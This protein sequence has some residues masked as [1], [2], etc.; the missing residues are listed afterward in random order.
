MKTERFEMRLDLD[1]LER[2]DSWR[3]KQSDIPSRAEAVRQLID[4]GLAASRPQE[5]RFSD[6]EKLI[7]W[8][9]KDLW[10]HQK[11]R[12]D[13]G[14]DMDFVGEAISLGHEWALDW[15]YPGMFG[16]D[17]VT[18]EEIVWEVCD[19]LNMWSFIERS[20]A[21]FSKEEKKQVEVAAPPFGDDVR[22]RGFSVN[23]EIEHYST[24]N[25]LINKLERFAEFSGRELNSHFPFLGGYRRMLVV[26]K[27]LRPTLLGRN[28]L[29]VSEVVDLLAEQTHPE[30]RKT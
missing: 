2:V 10:A 14:I 20:H 22:F 24:A 21:R 15:Q 6:G 8:A 5:S 7:F 17:S 12:Q 3:S 29:S 1:M 13:D 27:P 18:A 28:N 4:S 11:G 30:N 19:V 23:D 26:F 9:L 25:F 16:E